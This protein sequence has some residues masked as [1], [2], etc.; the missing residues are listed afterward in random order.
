MNGKVVDSLKSGVKRQ[1]NTLKKAVRYP[2]GPFETIDEIVRNTRSTIK[3]V[4]GDF[5]KFPFRR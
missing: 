2:V 4:T 3:S 5:L 1:V